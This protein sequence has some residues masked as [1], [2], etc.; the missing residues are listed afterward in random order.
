MILSDSELLARLVAFDSTSSNSNA[1][2]AAFIAGYLDRPSVAIERI[3]D[4][5]GE[6][7]NLLI[8]SGP[9]SSNRAGLV[10]SGHM[11]VVPARETG[12]DSD[13][14]RLDE[15]HGNFYG[16]GTA[17]MKGFLALAINAVA[18]IDPAALRNPL[19]LLLTYDE[20]VGCLGAK[21]FVDEWNEPSRIPVNTI[22]GEPTSLEAVRLHKGHLKLRVVT[23]GR[24]AHS[25]YPHL[26]LN[27]IEKAGEALRL[28]A[29]LREQLQSERPQHSQFFP[30]VPFVPLN[31]GTIHGGAAI[32]VVPDH[33]EIEV[34]LR[35]LPG[36]Q[37]E[38][39]VGRI[40]SALEG[41]AD[42]EL[43]SDSPPLLVSEDAEIHRTVSGMVGQQGTQSVS[44]ATDGGWLQKLGLECVL[45]GPGTI[46][47]AHRPN[48][49]LPRG[50]FEQASGLL[51]RLIH[52]YCVE[53]T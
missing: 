22:I 4:E 20:E 10:L 19:V 17:D 49:F 9:P 48:E 38:E 43:I 34:G 18:K 1:D 33:C 15:R 39:V 32:N 11:D 5:S 27:A 2:I 13:P 8:H 37:S 29:A 53:A 28:L 41:T 23:H 42:V 50:E 47:V 7:L 36:M 3:H 45:F 51:D 12:W 21:R 6:K 40:E 31:V 52:R 44:F 26:G 35:L 14:F 30:E 24:A 25:G 16:R 46:K